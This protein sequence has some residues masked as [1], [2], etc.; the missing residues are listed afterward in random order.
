MKK[1]P[2][3]FWIIFAA[4]IILIGLGWYFTTYQHLDFA[5]AKQNNQKFISQLKEKVETQ[6][7]K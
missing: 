6:I 4:A 2:F 5:S 1:R 7:F 3:V